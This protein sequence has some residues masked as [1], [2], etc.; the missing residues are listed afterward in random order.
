MRGL[1]GFLHDEHGGNSVEYALVGS[2]VTIVAI[3]AMIAMGGQVSTFLS[4]IIPYLS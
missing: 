1:W 2:I 4:G 3:G